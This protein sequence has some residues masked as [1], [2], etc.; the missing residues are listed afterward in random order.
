MPLKPEV[1]DYEGVFPGRARRDRESA[2][3]IESWPRAGKL[4]HFDD[5]EYVP[6]REPA[7]PAVVQ[8][9]QSGP[10]FLTQ[11]SNWIRR[12]GHTLSFAALFVFSIVL[13]LRPYEL[14]PGLS[15][16][17]SMA[18]YTGVITL[19]VYFLTQLSL[20][21]NL[22]ARPREINLVL[23]LG[24]AALLSMP[25]A[26]DPGDAWKTFSEML[27]KTMIIFVVIVNVVRTE[28]RLKMLLLLVLGV[29]IYLSINAINDYRA[30]IFVTGAAE[31]H[32]LRIGGRIKGLFENSNDLALHLVTMIPIAVA[33]GLT[34]RNPLK[35][36][37]YFGITALMIGAVTVTFSRGGFIGLVAATFVLVRRLGKKNRVATTG[38]LVFAV[39]LFMALAPGAFSG[40]LSTIFNS[41]ADL[42][43]SSSQRT[44]VLKRSVW[45]ALR[46]PIF[47]VGIGNA[48]H[49][50]PRNLETHNAYTQVA[51]EMGIAAM[52][53][54]ILFLIHPLRRMRAIEKQSGS[55]PGQRRFYYLSIG[56]QASLVGF[57]FSSFFGAVAYQWYLYYLVG[58]AVCLHRLYIMKFPPEDGF[59][60]ERWEH[61][62]SKKT[63][64][65]IDG[66]AGESK[67]A[68][69]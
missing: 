52:V 33:L 20:E 51:A 60:R 2:A 48:H 63:R 49:K 53:V 25:L 41:A 11:T 1:F 23:L 55:D 30:R 65:L 8:R 12:R 7:S 50:M 18:F 34:G 36:L 68:Q 43:G 58:Y 17:T 29:S 5:A 21:G 27:V 69:D 16:F 44:E 14:I 22:T 38:A 47:G 10:S 19:G 3:E 57:M 59:A 67:P 31:T 13:Y 42:T 56:L 40:R 61:P 4:K 62:F 45:V 54:Y 64:K 9:E 37:I 6:A 39:I 26:E 32:D 35:K 15:S 24:V 66:E 46:Y 28:L